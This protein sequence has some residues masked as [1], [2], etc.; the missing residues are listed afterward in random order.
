MH[1]EV[2]TYDRRKR[3]ETFRK[4]GEVAGKAAKEVAEGTKSF[5]KGIKKG[6]NKKEEEKK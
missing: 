4:T 6:F 1:R 3:Q 5:M 2:F